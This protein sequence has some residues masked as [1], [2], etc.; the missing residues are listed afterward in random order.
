MAM[1]SG[2]RRRSV[3]VEGGAGGEERADL[4]HEVGGHGLEAVVGGPAPV[5]AGGAVV[6]GA[7]PRVEDTLAQRVGLERDLD[8]GHGAGDRG[9][10]LVG[11]GR[12]AGDVVDGAA[13]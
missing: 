12:E 4:G 1:S 13:E 5:A 2:G 9:G 11:A 8:A 10:D 7:R 6:E 3:V